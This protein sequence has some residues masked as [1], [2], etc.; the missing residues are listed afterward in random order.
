MVGRR[1]HPGAEQRLEILLRVEAGDAD[2][3][4]S[5]VVDPPPGADLRPGDTDGRAVGETGAP[6]R[7]RSDANG[8]MTRSAI[9]PV[10]AMTRSALPRT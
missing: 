8:A 9:A 10:G 1:P 5:V 6:R 7:I 4:R 2:H 3:G